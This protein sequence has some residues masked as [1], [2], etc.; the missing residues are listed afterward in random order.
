MGAGLPGWDGVS[1]H[2]GRPGAP[3]HAVAVLIIEGSA[4]ISHQRLHELVASRLPQLPR[5]RSR[6]VGKPL[7]LGQPVWAEL[8]DYD[9]APQIHATTVHAPNSACEFT[10]LIGRLAGGA[11]DRRAP[12]WEAWSV[13]GLDGGRWAVAVKVSPAVIAGIAEGIAPM[14]AHLLTRDQH[15]DPIAMTKAEPGLGAPPSISELIADTVLELYENSVMGAWLVT[16]ALPDAIRAAGRLLRPPG[17]SEPP[18]ASS[19][20]GPVSPTVFN[21]RLSP[22]RAV[23]LASIRLSHLETIAYA[24]GGST[25]NVALAACTLSLRTWLRHHDSLPKHPLLMQ[26]PLSLFNASSTADVTRIGFPVDRDDPVQVLLD[27]HAATDGLTKAYRQSE[28]AGLAVDIAR[29]ASLLPPSVM[30]AGLSLSTRLPWWQRAP[31][32]HGIV[33]H[34]PGPSAKRYCAGAKVIGMHTV[35]PLED[36]CGLSMTLTRHGDTL[37]F[38]ICVCPDNVPEVGEIASGIVESVDILLAAAQQSPRGQGPSV[39]TRLAQRA[40]KRQSNQR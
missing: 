24:F 29:L 13:E 27:L 38:S 25:I 5:F 1:L 20:S 16:A 7:G 8:D 12:L 28:T 9:P 14:W 32:C 37:N 36:N 10:E 3:A 33:S 26:L 22:Q 23:A 4:G 31:T 18:E 34:V 19:V 17:Q 6:L 11:M 2:T 21:A 40:K 30:H 35:T 39:V 15:G